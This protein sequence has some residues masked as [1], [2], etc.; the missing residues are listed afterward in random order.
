MDET[1]V[2]HSKY[3]KTGESVNTVRFARRHALS[4]DL[5]SKH[6]VQNETQSGSKQIGVLLADDHPGSCT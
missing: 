1:R 4:M 6:N 2:V 3:E 5:F